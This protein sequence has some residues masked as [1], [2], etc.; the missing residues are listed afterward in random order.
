MCLRLSLSILGQAKVSGRDRGQFTTGLIYVQTGKRQQ[1]AY[2]E[3]YNRKIQKELLGRCHFNSIK[4]VQGLRHPLPL[5]LQRK[6]KYRDRLDDTDAG[7]ESGLDTTEAFLQ[8][9][10]LLP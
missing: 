6:T 10:I 1:N 5:D 2:V 3:R 9:G 4:E 7:I 8:N